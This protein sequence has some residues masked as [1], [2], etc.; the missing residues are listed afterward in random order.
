[1][2]EGGLNTTFL[3][4]VQIPDSD[5]VVQFDT[6]FPGHYGSRASHMHLTTHGN[7]TLLPNGTYTGGYANHIGQL[8]F[9]QDLRDDVETTYPY[10]LNTQTPVANLDDMIASD[11]ATTAFDPI[12]RYT[13]LGEDLSGRIVTSDMSN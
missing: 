12:V 9:D 4:G 5:G 13:Y 3:R 10:T 1:M 2:G 6:I 8:F 7:A 11:E